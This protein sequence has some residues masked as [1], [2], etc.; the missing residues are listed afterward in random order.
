[1]INI[2]D[3]S[4]DP[5]P[6]FN[7]QRIA[8]YKWGTGEM[9]FNE[10]VSQ[11]TNKM[12]DAVLFAD[13]TGNFIAETLEETL[14]TIAFI[15][16]YRHFQQDFSSGLGLWDYYCRNTN[17][18]SK[19]S[20]IKQ[21]NGFSKCF[22]NYEEFEGY[23]DIINSEKELLSEILA[24]NEKEEFLQIRQALSELGLPKEWAG[25]F[26]T[27]RVLELDA[28]VYTMN[29]VLSLKWI[30]PKIL[31]E[32][33]I[34]RAY[35][36]LEMNSEYSEL[37]I[38]FLGQLNH[39]FDDSIGLS[40]K[41]KLI[42]GVIQLLIFLSISHPD[43]ETIK[44]RRL[45]KL[46]CLPGVKLIKIFIAFFK[47]W[48]EFS[49]SGEFLSEDF[50]KAIYESAGIDYPTVS[51]VAKGWESF[52]R[53]TYIDPF[54]GITNTRLG[55]FEKKYIKPQFTKTQKPEYY[56]HA[57]LGEPLDFFPT[58]DALL[59][60]DNLA[61]D[62]H[63]LGDLYSHDK[64]EYFIDM[65]KKNNTKKLVDFFSGKSNIFK[66]SYAGFNGCSI[67]KSYCSKIDSH[68]LIPK[69]EGCYVSKTIHDD[70]PLS[71]VF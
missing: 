18:I 9:V 37:Y 2:S 54:L 49:N 53:G 55:I 46:S 40:E 6:L 64:K 32:P 56:S 23:N 14:K 62:K 25:L 30:N 34:L 58:Y 29:K 70:H 60:I 42:D 10:K 71:I 16:E 22:E 47:I 68:A 51:E 67:S 17:L 24:G 1:M 39:Y 28:T 35:N 44:K 48:N 65:R 45:D 7:D 20:N 57:F 26:S 4:V 69:D 12:F 21:L 15:H 27:R 63:V 38:F 8:S 11:S 52:F 66:C 36:I 61:E 43:P 33:E 13:M 5:S 59:L 19:L 31:E 3:S 41:Y 50:E